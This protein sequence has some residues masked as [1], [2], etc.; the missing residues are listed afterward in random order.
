MHSKAGCQGRAEQSSTGQPSGRWVTSARLQAENGTARR[1]Q[2][3]RYTQWPLPRVVETQEEEAPGGLHGLCDTQGRI[4]WTPESYTQKRGHRQHTRRPRCPRRWLP[5]GAFCPEELLTLAGYLPPGA[6]TV[7]EGTLWPAGCLPSHPW[8][9]HCPESCPLAWL[10]ISST[11]GAHASELPSGRLAVSPSTPGARTVQRRLPSDAGCLP[12]TL[13]PALSRAALWPPWLST[14]HPRD[15]HCPE[16]P[17]DA[18]T[19]HPWGP[20]RPCC[21]SLSTYCP[22]MPPACA[23]SPQRPGG[24]LRWKPP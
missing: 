19:F 1:G 4:W 20:D 11:P 16:L 18:C 5:S 13:R 14:F 3:P 8:G 22:F 12:S 2:A 9:P 6:H 23:V 7:Q 21:F 15:P 10:S 17:S 24:Q